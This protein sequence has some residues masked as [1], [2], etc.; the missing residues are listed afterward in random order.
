MKDYSC[1][2]MLVKDVICCFFCV[3]FHQFSLKLSQY[4]LITI[5]VIIIITVLL[6]FYICNYP[7]NTLY[8]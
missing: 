5:A 1:C 8:L 6:L 4:M 2:L 7:K 3:T